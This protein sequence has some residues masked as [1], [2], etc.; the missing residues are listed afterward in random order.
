ML[1]GSAGNTSH[2]FA[3]AAVVAFAIAALVAFTTLSGI[4]VTGLI[5]LGL[6]LLAVHLVWPGPWPLRR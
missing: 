5:A 1:T 4:S 3:I 6:A 2:M